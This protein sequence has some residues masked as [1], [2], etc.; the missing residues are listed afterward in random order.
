MKR[1][2]TCALLAILGA[3]H[4]DGAMLVYS[5]GFSF[6]KYQYVI[7][8]KPD[9]RATSPDLYGLDVELANL[10]TQYNMKVIGD[11]EYAS[12]TTDDRSKTLLARMA[13]S[14]SEDN[15]VITVSFDDMVSGRTGASLTT[16]AD[17]DLF[18]LD[19]RTLAFKEAAKE[20]V[21][22]VQHDKGLTISDS[23]GKKNPVGQDTTALIQPTG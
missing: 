21:K 6:S 4:D 5:S 15:L 16:H 17:G 20:F 14:A 23:S 12:L 7:V 11:K 22:A 9:G 10:L 18:D 13:L 1:I 2:L 19:S 8:Q 3:C